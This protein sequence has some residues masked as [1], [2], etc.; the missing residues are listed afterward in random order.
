M[1]AKVNHNTQF[2]RIKGGVGVLL[3]P[4]PPHHQQILKSFFNFMNPALSMIKFSYQIQ[5]LKAFLK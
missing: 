4:P 1:E 5:L 3:S 2:Y